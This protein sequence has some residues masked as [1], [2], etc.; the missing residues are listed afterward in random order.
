MFNKS[1]KAVEN[2]QPPISSDVI[3]SLMLDCR[4]H[5]Y[6]A[7]SIGNRSTDSDTNL[8]QIILSQNI[9]LVQNNRWF[10]EYI[11]GPKTF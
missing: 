10:Q 3:I 6:F 7:G 11:F 8:W 9:I 1:R 5:I 2:Y 4:N